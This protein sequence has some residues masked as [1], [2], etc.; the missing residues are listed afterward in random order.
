VLDDC[1]RDMITLICFEGRL[2]AFGGLTQIILEYHDEIFSA[3]ILIRPQV[4]RNLFKERNDR[5]WYEQPMDE[6]LFKERQ[7]KRQMQR[8]KR[9][10]I[11]QGLC[12]DW[13]PL[14]PWLFTV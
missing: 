8:R 12:S 7:E 3:P 6:C 4:Q 2:T 13:V 1:L 11:S 9:W 5:K 14:P 10:E